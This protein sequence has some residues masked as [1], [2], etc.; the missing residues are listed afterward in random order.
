MLDWE[1]LFD[2][3]AAQGFGFIWINWIRAFLE[4]SKASILVNRT[5][6][7]YVRYRKGLRQGDPLSM[8]LFVLAMDVLSGMFN[9]A[10]SSGVLYGVP[11]GQHRKMCHLKYADDLIIL[12]AGGGDDLRIAKLILFLFEGISDLSINLHKTCLYTT[13]PGQSQDPSLAQ[14]LNCISG[15]LPL[16]YLGIPISGSRPCRQDWVS[17]VD[18]TR[19]HISSWK[20]KCLSLVAAHVTQ[21]CALCNPDLLNVHV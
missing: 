9:H 17:L 11:L 5:K 19:R 1:F 3:L 6:S 7:G 13:M 12:S 8:L 20:T 21:L 4:S 18:K 16:T 14:T 10:L 15:L 2:L